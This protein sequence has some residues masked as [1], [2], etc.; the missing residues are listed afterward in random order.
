MV[1]NRGVIAAACLVGIALAVAFPGAGL[2][3]A[4]AGTEAEPC[5]LVPPAT[6]PAQTGRFI[7]VECGAAVAA[8]GQSRIRHVHND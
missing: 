3:A 5:A 7:H 4:G 6:S 8:R 1:P 2:E